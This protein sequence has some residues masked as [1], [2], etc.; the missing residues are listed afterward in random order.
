LKASPQTDKRIN[1][2][3]VLTDT[4]KDRQ[5]ALKAFPQTDKRTG[6]L[7][8]STDRRVESSKGFAQT[9]GKIE[10]LI[11]QGVPTDR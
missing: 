7:I 1:S 11:V 9:D 4:Q 3:S 2:E 10:G 8:I 5:I 6:G